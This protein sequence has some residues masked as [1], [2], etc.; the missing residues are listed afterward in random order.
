MSDTFN[1]VK[2][3]VERGAVR[4]SLH[5]YDELAAGE[6]LFRE[7]MLSI[8][9]G[10]VVEDS[11][12]YPKGPCVLVLQYDRGGNPIH[13]VWGITK[14]HSEPAVVV[15]AYRPDISQW[16]DGYKRRRG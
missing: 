10:T 3:L 7:I 14:G 12:A 1:Q 6:I 2:Q 16:E 13:V 4:V 11:P 8:G 5:G 9:D 15:T